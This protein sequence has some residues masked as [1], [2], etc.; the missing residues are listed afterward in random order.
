LRLVAGL[1]NPGPEYEGT[2]HNVGFE[3]LDRVAKSAG[4]VV[5]RR[6]CRSLTGRGHI[7]D[8]AV[9]L[10]KPMTFM[11]ASGEAIFGLLKK[12]EVEPDRLLVV[13]DEVELPLG[14][15]RLK[16]RGSAGGHNGLKSI[17]SCLGSRD[18]PRLR[19][20]VRGSRYSRE[21]ELS[22]YVLARFSRSE[23]GE[24]DEALD[25]A[26]E[27]VRVWAARGI[28]EAMNRFNAVPE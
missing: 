9:L 13:V 5:K 3:V 14:T 18:Y 16:P 4:I 22:D 26:A 23:R 19:I 6:E 28:G 7:G 27:A 2:R 15:L 20:G 10:A 24:I 1:G 8:E 12:M 17:E 11:N 25:R 21:R